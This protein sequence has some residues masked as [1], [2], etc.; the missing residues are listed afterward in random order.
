MQRS[1]PPQPSACPDLTT[2][3]HRQDLP[4]AG[5]AASA[6]APTRDACLRWPSRQL[7][8]PR[9]EIEIEHGS[10]IYRLRITAQGK[11]ILTK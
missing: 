10:A 11:L 9:R 4:Q 2:A 5:E 3:G 6:P 8:G 7:F 1:D